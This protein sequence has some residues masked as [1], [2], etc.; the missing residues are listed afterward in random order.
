MA[1][2]FNSISQ[3]Q[4]APSQLQRQAFFEQIAWFLRIFST[5]SA[6]GCGKPPSP[7]APPAAIN[8]VTHGAEPA[9]KSQR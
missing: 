9:K 3:L 2:F 5:I 1:T 8:L 7:L 4:H 6:P